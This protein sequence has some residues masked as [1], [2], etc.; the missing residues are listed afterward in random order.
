VVLRRLAGLGAWPAAAVALFLLH[1]RVTTGSWFVAGGFYENDPYYNGLAWRSL[2]AVW[3]GTHQ[4]GG[5]VIETL[6]LATAGAL[7]WRAMRT[8]SG[9]ALLVPVA[10]FASAALPFYAFFEGHPYRVRYMAS[11]AAACVLFCGIAAGLAARRQRSLGLA[12]AAML[13][14]SSLVE[15]PPWDRDAPLK[16]ESQWDS[17]RSLERRRVTA[18]LAAEYRGERIFASMASLAHYIQEL[19]GEGLA[20][21]D[22][23]HEGNGPLWLDGLDGGAARQAGWMLAE[24]Q[25][26]G[27]DVLA[28]RIRED[29]GFA[30]GMTRLCEGGGVALY[31][32]SP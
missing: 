6:A 2:V 16:A 18:C 22:F 4:I 17:P 7:A 14:V 19:S 26:E 12:L 10:L 20:I 21:A 32:R 15:S 28:R 30:R 24:E 23:V 13:V 9:G 29:P 3:W 27:G 8:P 31:R 11:L 25:S 1:S 5:Y